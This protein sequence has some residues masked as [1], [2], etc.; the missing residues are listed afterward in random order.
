M[1]RET[2]DAFLKVIVPILEKLLIFR[3][4]RNAQKGADDA[5]TIERIKAANAAAAG[6]RG[7]SFDDRVRYLKS[8]GRVR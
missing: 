3:A 7:Q 4:G 1:W 2:L 6:M 5:A 8:R